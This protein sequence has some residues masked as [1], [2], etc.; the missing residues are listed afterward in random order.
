MSSDL[1]QRLI[2]E[3]KVATS[4]QDEVEKLNQ[5]EKLIRGNYQLLYL[6]FSPMATL[7]DSAS[8]PLRVWL[9]ELF[10]KAF[11]NF[12]LPHQIAP[13]LP[14]VLNIVSKFIQGADHAVALKALHCAAAIFPSMLNLMVNHP[15]VNPELW[16]SLERLA[17]IGSG[18]NV[19]SNCNLGLAVVKLL[20]VIVITLTP[21]K[22]SSRVV[23]PDHPF[24]PQT[25]SSLGTDYFHHLVS[26]ANLDGC[27]YTV[28]TCLINTLTALLLKRPHVS[29]DAINLMTTLYHTPPLHFGD[30]QRQHILKA[31][32]LQ[33]LI[34][35]RRGEGKVQELAALALCSVGR[36][37]EVRNHYQQLG[38]PMPQAHPTPSIEEAGTPR[39]PSLDAPLGPEMKRVRLD[40]GSQPPAQ[41]APPFLP[42]AKPVDPSFCPPEVVANLII[43][44]LS[45]LPP[46]RVEE[47]IKEARKSKVFEALLA[48]PATR[49]APVKAHAINSHAL[50]VR[51]PSDSPPP[52]TADVETLEAPRK[53]TPEALPDAPIGTAEAPVEP[54]TVEPSASSS[55]VKPISHEP[56]PE[57][58][59]ETPPHSETKGFKLQVPQLTEDEEIQCRWEACQRILESQATYTHGDGTTVAW[60]QLAARLAAMETDGDDIFG[61]ETAR[62]RILEFVLHDFANRVDLATAWLYEE[63]LQAPAESREA[64]SIYSRALGQLVEGYTARLPTKDVHLAKLLLGVPAVPTACFPLIEAICKRPNRQS[65]VVFILRELADHRPTLRALC[66][67]QMLEFCLSEDKKL[68]TSAIVSA[69]RWYGEAKLAAPIETFARNALQSLTELPLDE[70]VPALANSAVAHLELYF[71]LTSRTPALLRDIF[72][73]YPQLDG[74]VRLVM[75]R[76]IAPLVRLLGPS[77]TPLLQYLCQFPPGAE[78]L[79]Y[80]ALLILVPPNRKEAHLLQRLLEVVKE[81]VQASNLSVRFLIPLLPFLDESEIAVMLPTLLA[82]LTKDDQQLAK[83]FFIKLATPW[84]PP[85]TPPPPPPAQMYGL[86]PPVAQPPLPAPPIMKPAKILLLLHCKDYDLFRPQVIKAICLCLAEVALFPAV[87]VVEALQQMVD[88]SKLPVLLMRT[89]IEFIRL[90]TPHPAIAKTVPP[91]LLRLV[92]KSVWTQP[93]LWEGFIRVC[94]LLG[95]ASHGVLLKLPAPEL[96]YALSK[97]AGL[98]EALTKRVRAH[99]ALNPSAKEPMAHLLHLFAEP[100]AGAEGDAGH[101]TQPAPEPIDGVGLTPEAPLEGRPESRPVSPAS[102]PATL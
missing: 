76:E 41:V 36:E 47:A 34:L 84:G 68:R 42:R 31:V 86:A 73:I 71:A 70:P 93:T 9:C 10:R 11:T 23:P 58:H 81:E 52:P 67:R 59:P 45:S 99:L 72:A 97:F 56:T 35:M 27:S 94:N 92:H 3:A 78:D 62:G 100:E 60:H 32:R 37:V 13:V 22:P 64:G 54:S 90:H 82:T 69:R 21:S 91:L 48:H 30:F 14:R 74:T 50:K 63:Y 38:R 20:Q 51:P 15:K 8:T 43:R 6:T 19:V 39:R 4:A 98:K 40:A 7:A 53:A 75:E 18:V 1:V 80:R 17:Q 57:L 29:L 102:S 26:L 66:L 95:A 44:C 77:S 79:A 28:V 85:P 46:T 65:V 101:L 16:T 61:S 88:M 24:L 5:L 83:D 96:A 55:E 12:N 33:F 25:I 87:E 2:A 89:M 49:V